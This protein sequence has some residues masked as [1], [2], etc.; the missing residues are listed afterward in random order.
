TMTITNIL[1]FLLGMGCVVQG[2]SIA[3]QAPAILQQTLGWQI[4]CTGAII[5][6]I[7]GLIFTVE[8]IADRAGF[9]VSSKR[10]VKD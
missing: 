9:S 4:I 10:R 8:N 6:A 2:Y 7:A 5:L 1:A 3:A